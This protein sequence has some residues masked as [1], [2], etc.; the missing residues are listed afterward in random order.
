MA[1]VLGHT[2]GLPAGYDPSIKIYRIATVSLAGTGVDVAKTKASELYGEST[3]HLCRGLSASW[4]IPA[5]HYICVTQAIEEQRQVHLAIVPQHGTQFFDL[6]ADGA[7]ITTVK[8]VL[9][10]LGLKFADG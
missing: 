10:S 8:G 5:T 2:I 1:K 3:S 4:N 7:S 6:D 9:D